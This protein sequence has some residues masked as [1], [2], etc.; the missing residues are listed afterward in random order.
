MHR[1][2]LALDQGTTSS[3]A[4]LFDL[5]GNILAQSQYEFRQVYLQNGF[6]EHDPYDILE[7]Q[8]RA[9]SDVLGIAGVKS[10]EIISIGISNQRETTIIWE[11]STGKPVYNAIVWQCRRTKPLC[12]ALIKDGL[13]EYVQ[14][15][16]GL[17]IDPYFSAT[18]IRYILDHID[19]GQLRA[20]KGE[21]L[22]GTVDT[23][24][25]LNL[26]GRHV[27]DYTNASR[28]MLFD[29]HN[30]RW[31]HALQKRLNI[32]HCMMPEVG[33]SSCIYGK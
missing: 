6:I 21:L 14:N 30:L 19:A 18:K 25:I 12:E 5:Y 16:T 26:T 9:I 32:P 7:T 15:T 13:N 17:L 1:Y 8:I 4:I 20:E 27:T 29:I 24:L 31:D 33:P 2:L 28:T 3:R 22:F 23:W 10:S 11:K